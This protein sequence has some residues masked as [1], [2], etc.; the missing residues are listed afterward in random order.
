M[1]FTFSK[2]A[3]QFLLKVTLQPHP[4]AISDK[5]GNL[6]G[7]HIMCVSLSDNGDGVNLR[8]KSQLNNIERLFQN[9]PDSETEIESKEFEHKS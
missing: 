2:G 8:K 6:M 9:T 1:S 4:S 7:G 3:S 5:K